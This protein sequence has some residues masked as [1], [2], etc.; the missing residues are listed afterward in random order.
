MFVIA[1]YDLTE[2]FVAREDL[3]ER[4]KLFHRLRRKGLSPI[5]IYESAKPLSNRPCLSR[6]V[7]EF[8]GNGAVAQRGQNLGRNEL[9]ISKP[10]QEVFSGV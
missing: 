2:F 3:I 4:L 10:L 6:D 9:S 5:L 8:T 7:V 1:R